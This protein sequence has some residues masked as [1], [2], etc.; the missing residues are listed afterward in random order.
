[1]GWLNTLVASGMAVAAHYF[2]W[3]DDH[4]AFECSTENYAYFSIFNY[5]RQ[6]DNFPRGSNKYNEMKS[7]LNPIDMEAERCGGWDKCW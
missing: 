1:M 3:V 4:V 7:I 6:L 5:G 2:A